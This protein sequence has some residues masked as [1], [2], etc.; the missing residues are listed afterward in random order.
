VKI[1]LDA[2]CFSRL[3]DDQSQERIRDEAEAVEHIFRLIRVGQAELVS[4]EALE[5]EVRR[6]PSIERRM[7]AEALLS[8]ASV[9][10]VI[11]PAVAQRARSL[12]SIGYGV[13]TPCIWRPQS[14]GGADIVLSTDDRLIRRAFRKS[15]SPRI[16][17][18]NPVS[19][20]QEQLR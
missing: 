15:G 13:S 7:E 9:R 14:W 17:V 1:Y 3:T 20:I 19:W 6:T 2:C 12:V 18:Q 8:L 4:S 11:D 10:V 5:D 16:P